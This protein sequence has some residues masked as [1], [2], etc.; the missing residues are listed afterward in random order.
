MPAMP[1][2]ATRAPMLAPIAIPVISGDSF[3]AS[4]NAVVVSGGV[5]LV[6]ALT[7]VTVTVAA[8]VVVLTGVIVAVAA[9]VF[10]LTGVVVAALVVSAG[11]IAQSTKRAQ[12]DVALQ[13]PVRWQFSR[14]PPQLPKQ[15]LHHWRVLATPKPALMHAGHT[16]TGAVDGAGVATAGVVSSAVAVVVVSVVVAAAVGTGVT[17]PQK[18]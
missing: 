4:E 16:S 12:L 13:N 18:P 2:T 8:L 10:V 11:T 3:A 5:V 17:S 14:K 9:L 7:G 6:V 15:Q 1:I